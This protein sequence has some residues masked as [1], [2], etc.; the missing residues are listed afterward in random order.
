M[1]DILSSGLSIF[2]NPTSDRFF[3]ETNLQ[4]Q[5]N[6]NISLTD[7]AGKVIIQEVA[8]ISAGNAKHVISIANEKSGMY[9]LKVEHNGFSK[10]F[11][12][13]KY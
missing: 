13:M 3:I 11:K 4:Q 7:I 12:L 10:I 1:Q 5:A 8:N 2:P 9:I 6:L